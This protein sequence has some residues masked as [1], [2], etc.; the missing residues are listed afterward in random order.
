MTLR[1]RNQFGMTI[2]VFRMTYYMPNQYIKWFS[3]I[4]KHDVAIVGGKGAK[5]GEMFQ[6]GFSV[7][8]GFVVTAQGFFCFIEENNLE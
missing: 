4:D 3:Q 8:Y 6:A 2:E 1:C 7:P 5:L